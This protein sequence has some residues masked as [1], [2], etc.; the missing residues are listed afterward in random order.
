MKGKIPWGIS[1]SGYYAFD[2]SMFYQYRAFGIPKLGLS[3]TREP[4]C[5]IAPYATML[6]L[7]T[8]PQAALKNIYDLIK[9]GALGEFGCYEALDFTN[10]RLR[11]NRKPMLIQ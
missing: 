6:A 11:K 10:A 4:E 9:L 7:L 8:D 1:E 5:V 3:P 2:R